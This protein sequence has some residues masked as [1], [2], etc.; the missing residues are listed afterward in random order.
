MARR[1]RADGVEEITLTHY[2][3]EGSFRAMKLPEEGDD[4]E[5]RQRTN[6]EIARV[7]L[8]HGLDL[9]VQV[10]NAEEYFAWLGAR[11]H[12]Y[13]ALQEYPEGMRWS[14]DFGQVD[15][16]GSPARRMD[17]DD[18]QAEAVYGGVQGEGGAGGAAG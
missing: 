15:K 4:F 18:G 6:A 7:M 17:P 8:A 5:H 12:T 10:L 9:K 3:D 2:A 16:L 11:P 1:L 14:P 13:Q